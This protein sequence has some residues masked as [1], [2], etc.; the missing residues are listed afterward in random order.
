MKALNHKEITKKYLLFLLNFSVLLIITVVCYYF[1]LKTDQQ[2]A[3]L[4]I[5]KQKEHE[6]IFAKRAELEKKV[7][8][9]TQYLTMLADGQGANEEAL[10]N[11]ISIIKNSAS[12]ELER[13]KANGDPF[14]YLLFD[15]VIASAG[16]AFNNRYLLMQTKTK[17]DQKRQ[18]L[19][20]CKDAD[21]RLQTRLNK[22]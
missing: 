3:R 18:E 6:Y 21:K 20:D 2:Q 11:R 19:Y 14:P 1:Y 15:K 4:I 8:T 5:E 17:E 16:Y 22:N 7:D 9:L 12:Q 13:L 10:K